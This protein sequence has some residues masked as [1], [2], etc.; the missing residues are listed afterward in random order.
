MDQKTLITGFPSI[1]GKRELKTALEEYWAKKITHSQLISAATEIQKSQVL[2][3]KQAGID[4]ISCNDFTLYDSMLDTAVMVNAIPKRFCSIENPTE[5]Y[6]AMARGQGGQSAM[7]MTKWFN[8]NYHYIVPELSKDIEFSG[9]FS[10]ISQEFLMLSEVGVIPKINLIGPI[11][12][13]GLSKTKAGESPYCYFE[14]VLE[15]YKKLLSYLDCLTS[16]DLYVQIEEP[17]FSGNPSELQLTLISTTYNNLCD[18]SDRIKIIFTTY[19]EHTKEAVREIVK[20]P[21]WAVGLDFVQ[22]KKNKEVLDIIKEKVLVAGVVDGR[23]IWVNNID[24]SVE[25]LTSISKHIGRDKIIVSTSCSLLHVPYTTASELESP[26][27]KWMSFAVEKVVELNLIAKIFFNK[28]L[29]DVDERLVEENK[30]ATRTRLMSNIVHNYAVKKRVATI[31]K[32]ERN[33]SFEQRIKK[34][35]EVLLLPTLPTTTIGS[36][37]QTLEIREVRR[38]YK[39]GAIT[40]DEYEK[41]IKKYI[42]NCIDIQE[43]IGIDVFVHGEPER[44]DMVEYF[45]EM[46]AGFQITKNGWVRSYGSRCVKPP[47]IYGDILRKEPMTIKWISYAQNKTQKK[48][49]GMLTGPVTIL[50]W[51]FV[52]DDLPR[53]EISRQIAVAIS[54]EIEDLQNAGIKIIQVDEAAFKEGYPLKSEDVKSYEQWAVDNFKLA[55]SKADSSTQIHTHMCYSEFNEIIETISK[56]DADVI[57]IETSRSGNELLASFKNARY[58]N[59]IG[60]GVYDIHSPQIPSVQDILTQIENLVQIF[61]VEKLWINPDCGLKTRKWEE[62]KPALKNMVEAVRQFR[63]KV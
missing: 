16:E 12:F 22:G 14:Q 47:I 35:R 63:Q 37:P 5:R 9:N 54:D 34:Q 44:N 25:L 42:D 15:V 31:V 61:P 7:E 62:V 59:E 2:F 21:V 43:K 10:K 53:G 11:T 49:K 18:V 36:F 38:K 46:L 58:K 55:V 8:T 51:S 33:E 30:S 56:M 19:F 1:G 6:F 28:K 40:T 57:T 17:I 23:N 13:L 27:K 45:G 50:N 4:F 3:Q 52:R 39:I 32:T 48:V 41:E 26:I 24:E 60:P 20:T 29:T